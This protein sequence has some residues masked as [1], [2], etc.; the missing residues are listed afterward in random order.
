MSDHKRSNSPLDAAV[1]HAIL[2]AVS[3]VDFGSVEITV[4]Q[5]RVVAIET[6]EKHRL[7]APA[8]KDSINA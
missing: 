6:R 1:S 8:K 3:K 7:E 5:G 2:D 4:H